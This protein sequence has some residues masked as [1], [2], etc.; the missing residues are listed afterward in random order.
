MGLRARD[1]PTERVLS[2]TPL[3][4]RTADQRTNRYESKA[5]GP[6]GNQSRVQ[7]PGLFSP[8]LDRFGR[9]FSRARRK[10]TAAH[11]AATAESTRP[12]RPTLRAYW[13]ST[14]GVEWVM[15]SHCTVNYPACQFSLGCGIVSTGVAK[16][17]PRCVFS[18]ASAAHMARLCCRVRGW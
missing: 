7:S 3:I 13:A 12:A 14:C 16:C 6:T 17:K 11:P 15:S 8:S 4:I 1:F 9:K 10:E 5:L 2:R 18:R